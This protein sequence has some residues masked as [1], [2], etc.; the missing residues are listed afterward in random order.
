MFKISFGRKN[1]KFHTTFLL[2]P[3]VQALFN[4][5]FV[6]TGY[7]R[8]DGCT[9]VDVKVTNLDGDEIDMTKGLINVAS[10]GTYASH[11]A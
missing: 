8:D 9:P 2:V 4:V 10:R 7:G 5:Y 3:D 1:D 6:I 11:S